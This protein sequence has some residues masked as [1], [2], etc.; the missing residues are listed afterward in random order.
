MTAI[1]VAIVLYY[2]KTLFMYIYKIKPE[3]SISYN[4]E[5]SRL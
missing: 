1:N 4:M 2:L 5:Q 3:T